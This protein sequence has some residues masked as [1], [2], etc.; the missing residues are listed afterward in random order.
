VT[1]TPSYVSI[2][3]AETFSLS[4]I[5]V[6]IKYSD[7]SETQVSS[8]SWELASGSGNINGLIFYPPTSPET[9]EITFQYEENG[10]LKT[11][12]LTIDVTNFDPPLLT[13]S[14]PASGTLV[15]DIATNTIVLYFSKPGRVDIKA[16]D[17]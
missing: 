15:A 5:S 17:P 2:N 4:D 12:K 8:A 1:L 11:A 13:G 3:T 10:V 6:I 9:D 16:P 14:L 7:E